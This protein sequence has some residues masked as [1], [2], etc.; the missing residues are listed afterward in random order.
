MLHSSQK[1]FIVTRAGDGVH[2]VQLVC[3]LYINTTAPLP[4]A[5]I[6][7]TIYDMKVEEE[8]GTGRERT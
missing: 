2:A 7:R 3:T 1:H 6:T 4:P 8:K 5:L